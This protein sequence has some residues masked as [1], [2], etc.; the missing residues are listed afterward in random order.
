MAI[1]AIVAIVAI[2]I[3]TIVEKMGTCIQIAVFLL[4]V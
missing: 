1:M 2:I 4:Q 3:V